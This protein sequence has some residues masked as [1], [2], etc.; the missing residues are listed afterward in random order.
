MR[1]GRLEDTPQPASVKTD[2]PV[3]DKSVVQKALGLDLSNMSE[4]LRKKFKI[5]DGVKGVV[6]VG[7]DG[8]SAASEKRL[9]AGDV[10]V[11]ITDEE[12]A[13][14]ADVQKRIDQLK[15]EGKKTALLLVANAEGDVRF[16]ALRWV[17]GRG[18]PATKS[19]RWSMQPR[20]E[21]VCIAL[22]TWE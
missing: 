1:L 13:T 22:M 3:Q 9:S 18:A 11:K 20:R 19:Q 17:A 15:K 7:V 2:A 5:K 21:L 8:G 10:I 12:V 6:I 4:D 14:P 16:V